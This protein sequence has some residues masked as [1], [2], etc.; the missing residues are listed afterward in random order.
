MLTLGGDEELL[1]AARS[2][3]RY[4]AGEV[5]AVGVHFDRNGDGE[6]ASI[7]G[8]ELRISVARA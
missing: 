3:E 8:R 2:H 5:L 4:L 1:A 6:P 7:E